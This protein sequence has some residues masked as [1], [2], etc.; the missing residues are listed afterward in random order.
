MNRDRLDTHNLY[1]LCIGSSFAN[2]Q[3]NLQDNSFRITYLNVDTS[4]QALEALD[5]EKIDVILLN[6]PDSE[7]EIM[8]DI[9]FLRRHASHYA[10]VVMATV[11]TEHLAFRAVQAGAQDYLLAGC[12]DKHSFRKIIVNAI[13]RQHVARRLTMLAHYDELTKLPNRAQF[14]EHLSM[15]TARAA[16]SHATVSLLFIDLDGFKAINDTYGH[17]VGDDYL[18]HIAGRLQM[19]VRS[20]DF[21]SRLGGDEFTVIV[22]GLEDGVVE[23]LAVAQKILAIMDEPIKLPSGEVFSAS[24]SIGVASL[25]GAIDSPNMAKLMEKADSAMYCAKQQGG[26]RFHFYDKVMEQEAEQRVCLNN[27]L[28]RAV[29]RQEFRLFYQPVYCHDNYTVAG[30][31]A[32]LRWID[33]ETGVLEPDQFIRVLE[34]GKLIQSVGKWILESACKQLQAWRVKHYVSDECWV[35]VN[36]SSKQFVDG[37]IIPQVKEALNNSGLPPACLQLEFSE[38][39]LMNESS[40]LKFVLQKLKSMGVIMALDNFGTSHGSLQQLKTIP[41]DMLKIDRSFIGRYLDSP[42]DKSM[43]TAI[44][45]LAHSLNKR[46]VAEGV[47]SQLVAEEMERIGCDYCQGYYFARPLPAEECITA[48]LKLSSPAQSKNQLPYVNYVI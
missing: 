14:I 15:A 16:R 9:K 18:R 2:P 19:A 22:E 8:T 5:S 32:L 11:D 40:S 12:F 4:L 39:L 26:N 17:S 36:V 31:E 34:E 37:E 13:E 1:A 25:D 41:V 24:C 3:L 44:V 48:C 28:A 23:P 21:L 30:F 42:S 33:P 46:V 38:R 45:Q 27:S 7:E 29:D 47:E 20:S 35:S 6:L 10:L 43:T